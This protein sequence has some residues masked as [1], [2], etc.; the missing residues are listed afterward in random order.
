[1]S[2]S[3]KE[4]GK[5]WLCCNPLSSILL[6][7]SWTCMH[8]SAVFL[9]VL[10]LGLEPHSDHVGSSCPDRHA[11]SWPQHLFYIGNEARW[12]LWI[13][14]NY[15]YK[16]TLTWVQFIIISNFFPLEKTIKIFSDTIIQIKIV[17]K[18]SKD[19]SFA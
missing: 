11:T 6:L 15:I 17:W 7:R 8:V 10:E 19:P 5:E 13:L 12:R 1:M 16:D 18:I 3:E 4:R 9:K 14:S 2:P